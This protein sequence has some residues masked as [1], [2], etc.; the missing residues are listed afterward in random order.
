[1]VLQSNRPDTQ[2]VLGQE[3]AMAQALIELMEIQDEKKRT[4]T[5]LEL[6]EVGTLTLLQCL[7]NRTKVRE[8]EDFVNL[9]CQ[10]KVSKNRLGRREIVN[11][12]SMGG[13]GTDDR[14]KRGSIKDLFSGIRN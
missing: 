3:E 11:T 10:F 4:L 14:R 8:L 9:F 1:M 13:L 12:V 2:R 5:D 7:A 6:E